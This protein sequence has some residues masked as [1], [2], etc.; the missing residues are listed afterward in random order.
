MEPNYNY[1][2]KVITDRP[3]IYNGEEYTEVIAIEKYTS[4][5]NFK[6]GYKEILK[7]YGNRKKEILTYQRIRGRW[8]ECP[9]PKI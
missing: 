3:I 9:K 2:I 7:K 8:Y 6:K 1:Y 4:V 5:E